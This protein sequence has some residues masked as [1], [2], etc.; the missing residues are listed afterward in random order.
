VSAYP[1]D[2]YKKLN[3]KVAT[4]DFTKTNPFITSI[5]GIYLNV[6]ETDQDLSQ[7]TIS[8]NDGDP[9]S[10][11]KVIPI[12][13]PFSKIA[14]YNK[15]GTGYLK[16]IIG[17]EL[18]KSA[19]SLVENEI[20]KLIQTQLD[21]TLSALRD[22]LKK[23]IEQ[24][25]LASATYTTNGDSS[26]TPLDT[27]YGSVVVFFL[28]VTAVGGTSPTLDLYVD[29]RDPASGKWVNQDKFATV[30]STGTWGLA[31]P[32]RSTKYRVRWVLG[33]TSPSFTFSVG[34]V[35]VK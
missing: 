25:Y 35:I 11:D 7:I 10:L 29:I 34:V 18:F 13:S 8:L 5:E 4:I 27:S 15:A 33:G 19:S 26:G 32:V 28:N 22:T 3:Y 23:N 12:I 17:T 2:A 1:S 30:S 20:R 24:T 9:V 6:L 16:L 14:I 21:I 31:L